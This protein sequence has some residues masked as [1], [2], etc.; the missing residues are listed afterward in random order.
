M[1]SSRM[2]MCSVRSEFDRWNYGLRSLARLAGASVCCWRQAHRSWWLEGERRDD[3][4]ASTNAV[5]KAMQNS[6]VCNAIAA[7][8]SQ[9]A[10]GVQCGA[11]EQSGEHKDGASRSG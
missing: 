6:L 5:V 2:H 4:I 11:N 9:N 7:R 10:I 1:A 3:K 8:R